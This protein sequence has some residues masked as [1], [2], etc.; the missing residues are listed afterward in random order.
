MLVGIAFKIAATLV[1]ALMSAAV[2]AV[3]PFYPVAQ[4]VFFCSFFALIVTF[5][6]LYGQG[7]FPQR[8]AT[9]LPFGHVLRSVS[10]GISMALNFAALALLPL[11]DVTALGYTTPLLIFIIAAFV[12]G[13]MVTWGRVGA[14]CVGVMIILWDHVQSLQMIFA[15]PELDVAAI[16]PATWG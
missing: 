15:R 12:L 11:P 7:H 5:I 8:L 6:W 4:I 10:G 1:F 13:E 16:A 14:V 9:L 3:S 2:K